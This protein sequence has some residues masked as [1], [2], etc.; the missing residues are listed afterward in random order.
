MAVPEDHPANVDP[1]LLRQ[2]DAAAPDDLIDAVLVLE[3]SAEPAPP[4]QIE[5]T[6]RG[7]VARVESEAGS[8]ISE[9]NVFPNLS[10]FVVRATPQIVEDLISQPEVGSALANRSSEA[11]AT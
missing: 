6:V 11:E 3:L 5:E 9:F 4:D 8:A 2:L 1:E 7:I 10:S